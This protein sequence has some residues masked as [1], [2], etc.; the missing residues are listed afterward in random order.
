MW[1]ETFL[2]VEGFENERPNLKKSS[3][4]SNL[5]RSPSYHEP[6]ASFHQSH[7]APEVLAI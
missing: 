3:I 5:S 4:D 6:S 1:P 7:E 2:V